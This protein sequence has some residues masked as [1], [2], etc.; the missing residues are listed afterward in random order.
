LCVGMRLAFI[1]G[2]EPLNMYNA[3]SPVILV[4]FLVRVVVHPGARIGIPRVRRLGGHL[5]QHVVC[6]GGPKCARL[7]IRPCELLTLAEQHAQAGRLHR[8]SEAFPDRRRGGVEDE[9]KAAREH[10][11]C[12]TGLEKREVAARAKARSGAEGQSAFGVV[13]APGVEGAIIED[14]REAREQH[15]TRPLRE[16][17]PGDCGV[18]ERL[19]E[20]ERGL[21][22]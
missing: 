6:C 22:T 5:P 14:R 11:Q 4:R 8:E 10:A 9:L 2:P 12:D 15:Q 19:D 17:D 7:A 18:F 1:D 20:Q 21:A 16:F 13:G 3:M